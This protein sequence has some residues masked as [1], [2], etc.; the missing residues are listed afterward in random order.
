[1]SN[2]F[3]PFKTKNIYE[4]QMIFFF[5][6]QSPATYAD[7]WQD[8]CRSMIPVFGHQA[9]FSVSERT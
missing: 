5:I 7:V 4:I 2:F 9:I 3:V 6:A 1:L 8:Y